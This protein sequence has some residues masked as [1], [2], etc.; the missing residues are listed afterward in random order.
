MTVKANM[1][2]AMK[3]KSKRGGYLLETTVLSGAIGLSLLAA[4][5]AFGQNL[6]QN[7]TVQNQKTTEEAQPAQL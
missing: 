7:A 6:G 1:G 3:M 5:P 4:M 2:V